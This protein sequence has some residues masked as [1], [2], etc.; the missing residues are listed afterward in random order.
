M[1]VNLVILLA[2]PVLAALGQI[3]V[4]KGSL[5]LKTDRGR[6]ALVRSLFNLPLMG[7]ALAVLAAP[8]LYFS[9]LEKV[10]LLYAYSFSALAYPLVLLGARFFLKEKLTSRH[11]LG[12]VSVCAGLIVWNL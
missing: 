9:A 12:I 1:G 3:L 11:W 2:V 6:A 8:L 5:R 7:G 4:K 10:P